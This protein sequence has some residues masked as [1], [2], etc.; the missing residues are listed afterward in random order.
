[1]AALVGPL[2]GLGGGLL[3]D[4]LG[5]PS[6]EQKNLWKE[7]TNALRQSEQLAGQAGVL[8]SQYS[9]MARRP[10]QDVTDYWGT[11]LRGNPQAMTSLLQPEISQYAKANRA[12]LQNI[13][14]FAPRGGGRTTAL[15]EVPYEQ[16]RNIFNLFASLRPQA[17]NNLGALG[18]TLASL[19]LA[20]YGQGGAGLVGAARGFGDVENSVQNARLFRSEMASRSGKALYDMFKNVDWSKL[21]GGGSVTPSGGPGD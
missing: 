12:A 18:E 11:L 7:Q 20:G 8:G 3:G 10:L 9:G 1:M 17:A 14:Q 21:F 19:G 2:I 13:S 4:L 16:N 6:K 5:R 15:A